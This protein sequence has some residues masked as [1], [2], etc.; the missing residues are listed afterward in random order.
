MFWNSP[1]PVVSVASR[2]AAPKSAMRSRRPVESTRILPPAVNTKCDI[3]QLVFYAIVVVVVVVV[4]ALPV[5][6]DLASS[7]N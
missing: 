4:N 1:D 6:W 3:Q 7:S 2:A 5:G